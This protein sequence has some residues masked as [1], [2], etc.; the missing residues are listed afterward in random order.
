M[1]HMHRYLPCQEGVTANVGVHG[2]VLEACGRLGG[3]NGLDAYFL[4][5]IGRVV[6]QLM[7]SL[8]RKEGCDYRGEEY[9]GSGLFHI[10]RCMAV[11]EGSY[12]KLQGL[13]IRNPGPGF[14]F[15]LQPDFG[16]IVVILQAFTH[17]HTRALLLK[18]CG[19]GLGAS[20]IRSST[21]GL[22]KRPSRARWG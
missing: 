8:G 7:S 4:R 18:V 6:Q 9:R 21:A 10:T 15:W 13:G 17:K 12:Q 5:V 3:V 14:L 19:S 16:I 22:P 1:A 11:L 2:A 20:D